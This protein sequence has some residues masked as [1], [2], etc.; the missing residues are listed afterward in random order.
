MVLDIADG[1]VRSHHL[2]HLPGEAA[3]GVD[4]GFSDDRAVFR[5]DFPFIAGTG[6]DAGHPV[7]AHD[8]G[9][10]LARPPGHG[11]AKPERVGMTVIAGPGTGQHAFG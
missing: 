7:A 5:H 8:P 6:I 2:R 9:A 1:Q 4:H 11:L 10:H 3:G